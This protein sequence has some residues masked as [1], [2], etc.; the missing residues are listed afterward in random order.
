MTS[1]FR[2]HFKTLIMMMKTYTLLLLLMTNTLYAQW[3]FDVLDSGQT[4]SQTSLIFP[5]IYNHGLCDFQFLILENGIYINVVI[6]NTSGCNGLDHFVVIDD[7]YY[8]L[9]I[10][11][12]FELND[13]NWK[14]LDFVDMGTCVSLS[15]ETILES[16]PYVSIGST[17]LQIRDDEKINIYSHDNQTFFEFDSAN[18]DIFCENGLPFVSPLDIIFIGA[19][20]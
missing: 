1:P 17:V 13:D 10:N 9:P 2:R 20:E 6:N 16:E 12:K 18:G 8:S 15:E 4:Q 3:T 14:V 7:F 11:F 19:F 5:V